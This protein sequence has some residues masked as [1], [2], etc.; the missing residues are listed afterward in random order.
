MIKTIRKEEMKT[1]GWSGG[2]TTEIMILPQDS[3]YKEKTFDVRISSATIDVAKSDFTKLDGVH[4]TLMVL[5]G[6]MALYTDDKL[7]ADLSPLEQTEFEGSD[8]IRCLGRGRDFNLMLRNG[9]KGSV[10][11]FKVNAKEVIEKVAAKCGDVIFVHKGEVELSDIKDGINID[12]G[13]AAFIESDKYSI[14]AQEESVFVI[15]ELNGF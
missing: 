1:V 7:L 11:G 3:S 13:N 2:T 5:D 4:R 10:T 6:K 12:K 8:N 9:Y 14:K 15:V